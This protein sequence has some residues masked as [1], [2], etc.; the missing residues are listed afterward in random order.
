M[1]LRTL[2]VGPLMMNCY[3]VACERTKIAAV[4]DPGD[5]TER[6]LSQ[7]QS[8][9]LNIQQII[10]THGHADHIAVNGEVKSATGAK[11]YI[12][13]ADAEML[14]SPEENLSIFFGPAI[15]SP[16]ADGFLNEGDIHHIGELEL[17]ILHL[18]G[19]SDGSIGLFCEN[20]L[21]CGD[22]VFNESIGR[23]DFPRGSLE[24]LLKNIKTKILALDDSI[25]L[26]PGHGP[27]T[28][29]GWE[30]RHNPFLNW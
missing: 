30:R 5:E 29:V 12:H 6:I 27:A 4:I 18:P 16:P 11:I 22:A 19:H 2:V 24:L 8:L 7:A 15:L 21:F 9:N 3:I 17:K 28:T 26:L 1:I 23:T 10:N 20:K 25:E 13:P 14:I